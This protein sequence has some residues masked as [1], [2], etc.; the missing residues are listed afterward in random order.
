MDKKEIDYTEEDTSSYYN[1]KVEEIIEKKRNGINPYPHSFK[2]TKSVE[3]FI[4]TYNT[5]NPG[6]H[7]VDFK[8]S[9]A[10]RILE[11]R[12]SSKLWFMT[13]VSN[14]FKVQLMFNLQYLILPEENKVV[15][16]K[17]TLSNFSRGDII[18]VSGFVGKS[19]KGEL[20]LFVEH[21]TILTPC[22]KLI[23]KQIYGLKDE[24]LRVKKRF[25]DLISNED[26]M[27]TFKIRNE[28]IKFLRRY[29]DNLYYIELQTPILATQVGGAS[30]KPF[31]TF[32]NDHKLNMCLRIATE[33]PLKMAVVGGMNAVY[34]LGPQFRN[35]GID[36]THHPEFY[37]LELYKTYSDYNDMM[38]I[39][40]DML[41]KLAFEIKGTYKF[42]YLPLHSDKEIEIDFTP[43]FRRMDLVTE[44]EKHIGIK[45]PN[46]LGTE[47]SRGILLDLCSKFSVECKDPKTN[48]RLL[49]KLVGHF[50]EPQCVNPTFIMNHPLVMSPLAKWHRDNPF[51]TERFE[52][53]CNC[54][55]L[56]N[57][58]TELNDPFIQRK[59]FEDQMKAKS[60][61]DDEAQSID[62]TFIEALE[63]GLPPTGGAGFGIER[64]VMLLANKNKIKDVILF[65]I[66]SV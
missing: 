37:S 54:F 7:L 13:I 11:I 16:F 17:K 22:L 49:D 52:L 15:N 3:K 62:E 26:T 4:E 6:D 20:S 45:L 35:E 5:I 66:G 44:L 27:K 61:G 48:A 46:N 32:L 28:V 47:E 2:I 10:G 25:L 36:I 40:E 33:L 1:T 58:Y 50:L 42:N 9:I 31:N 38:N 18:G 43:P 41:S 60:M 24:E 63:Y 29:L 57:A 59:T 55:E 56:A 65:P 19:K 21:S 64:L 12:D 51:L 8:E 39:C 14:G 23:P 53:F 34:D 30:A